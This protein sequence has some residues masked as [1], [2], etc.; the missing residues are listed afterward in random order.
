[1][2]QRTYQKKLADANNVLKTQG[3]KG[4]YDYDE[5]MRGM[6]NGMELIVAIFEEREPIYKDAPKTEDK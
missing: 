1:M 5:Y 2:S 4:N 3:Q 6:Y